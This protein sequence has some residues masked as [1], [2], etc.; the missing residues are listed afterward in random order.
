MLV[1]FLKACDFAGF[2]PRRFMLQTGAKNYGLHLGP[3]LIPQF[4]NDPRVG[5]EPNFYYPQE[6]AL[7]EYCS[8]R[9]VG[10]NVARPSFI[11][12]AVGD[13]LLNH[14]YGL[15]IY[16]S[17]QGHLKR[18]LQFPASLQMWDMIFDQSSAYMNAYLEEWMV[19]NPDAAN[20]AFNA[21]DD[22]HF[23]WGRFW[24]MLAR[25]YGTDGY[26]TPELD[27]SKFKIV[28]LALKKPPRG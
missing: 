17:V 8:K 22:S 15:A 14:L 7:K 13:N 20:Q 10:W 19:L 18:P 6:D 28:P 1:N 2:K 5:G 16:A 24:P 25:W 21:K 3:N 12:G 4:E 11:L 27:E 26:T 9:N 23:T